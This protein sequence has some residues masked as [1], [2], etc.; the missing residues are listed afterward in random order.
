MGTAAADASHSTAVRRRRMITR[1]EGDTGFVR[2]VYHGG[3]AAPAPAS[4]GEHQFIARD[5]YCTGPPAVCERR[6]RKERPPGT[7]K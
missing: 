5:G 6:I 4:R 1:G 2:R 7:R 3:P